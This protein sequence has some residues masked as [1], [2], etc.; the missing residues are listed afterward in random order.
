MRSFWDAKSG[1]HNKLSFNS[2]KH[3]FFQ[4]VFCKNWADAFKIVIMNI[5]AGS[6]FKYALFSSNVTDYNYL[7]IQLWNSV[8]LDVTCYSPTLL[9]WMFQQVLSQEEVNNVENEVNTPKWHWQE[10]LNGIV[11]WG[12]P[13]G[14]LAVKSQNKPDGFTLSVIEVLCHPLPL[15]FLNI[16]MRPFPRGRHE[17]DIDLWKDV[18]ICVVRIATT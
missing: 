7:L 8:T 18:F 17:T 14:Q 5:S 16:Y 10:F 2:A 15:C 1:Q 6:Y 4:K 9:A 11:P 13:F 3:I 12:S